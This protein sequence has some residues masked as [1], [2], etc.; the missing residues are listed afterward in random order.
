MKASA[1]ETC[2]NAE[3]KT[4]SKSMS[5]TT[6]TGNMINHPVRIPNLRSIYILVRDFVRSKRSKFKHVTFVDLLDFIC[7]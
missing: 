6:R 3:L 2:G 4:V 7:R 1:E 5:S